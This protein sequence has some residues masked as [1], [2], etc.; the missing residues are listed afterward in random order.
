MLRILAATLLLTVPAFAQ[1]A[2]PGALGFNR[3]YK[4]PSDRDTLRLGD[5]VTPQACLQACRAHGPAAGCWWLDGSGGF[6]RACRLCRTLAPQREE[7]R[8]DWAL[9]LSPLVS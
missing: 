1:P 5:T 3:F 6:P 7:W 4:C 2:G 9:P 8:N